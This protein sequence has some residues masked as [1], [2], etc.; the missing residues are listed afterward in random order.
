MAVYK[1]LR[2]ME[3]ELRLALPSLHLAALQMNPL[4]CQ[5]R[6]VGLLACHTSDKMNLVP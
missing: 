1:E 6:R 5:P 2:Q 4:C 3:M